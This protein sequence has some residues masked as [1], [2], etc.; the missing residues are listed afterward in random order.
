M[1]HGPALGLLGQDF[2]KAPG[3]FR[4]WSPTHKGSLHLPHKEL[5]QTLPSG[6]CE[7]EGP[8]LYGFRPFILPLEAED[9]GVRREGNTHPKEGA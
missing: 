6:H 7:H 4:A 2:L 5:T 3:G 1:C 9:G 8:S